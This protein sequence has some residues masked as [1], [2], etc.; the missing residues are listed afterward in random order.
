MLQ[1][2]QVST[3]L[4]VAIF[5]ESNSAILLSTQIGKATKAVIRYQPN[6]TPVVDTSNGL[7]DIR[8][9]VTRVKQMTSTRPSVPHNYN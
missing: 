2:K 3:L 9:N 1:E 7:E 5:I 8:F 4:S 6:V